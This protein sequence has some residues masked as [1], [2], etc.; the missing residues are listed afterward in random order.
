[1]KK[2]DTG[3]KLCEMVRRCILSYR[4]RFLKRD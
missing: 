3:E 2:G 4:R 1:M